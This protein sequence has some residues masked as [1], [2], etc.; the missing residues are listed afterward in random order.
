MDPADQ[1]RRAGS[2]RQQGW[3][4]VRGGWAAEERDKHPS[5]AG[6][7]VGNE[8]DDAP[9]HDAV[10][11]NSP[12]PGAVDQ[13]HAVAM[14]DVLDQ[15]CKPVVL[16]ALHHGID[17]KVERGEGGAGQLPVAEVAADHDEA[18]SLLVRGSGDVDSFERDDSA[19]HLIEAA[20]GH[21]WYRQPLLTHVL[22]AR[23]RRSPDPVF[24]VFG[25]GA[26]D[27]FLDHSP[28][29]SEPMGQPAQGAAH[30]FSSAGR[31]PA[32]QLEGKASHGVL[33]EFADASQGT[34]TSPRAVSSSDS[35][36]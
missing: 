35:L 7:L 22:E 26:S 1:E 30:S 5:P 32:E 14:A 4:P 31:Q 34:V 12:C 20:T 36:N 23:Q 2:E 16:D 18:L 21:V 17:G 8:G 10:R 28:S 25:K 13:P 15:L 9:G 19:A 29:P 24:V 3:R 6:V 33:E 27:L 11:Q